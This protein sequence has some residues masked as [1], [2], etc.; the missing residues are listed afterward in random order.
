MKVGFQNSFCLTSSLTSGVK[1]EMQRV[2]QINAQR[3]LA[4]QKSRQAD[5]S[6]GTGFIL[7]R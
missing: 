2:S 1:Q 3:D 6:S 7:R 4:C 5:S